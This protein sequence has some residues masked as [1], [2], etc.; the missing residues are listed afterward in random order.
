[1]GRGVNIVC[2]GKLGFITWNRTRP[3]A[4]DHHQMAIT[5]PTTQ[6]QLDHVVHHF[7]STTNSKDHRQKNIRIREKIV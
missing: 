7:R 5:V 1:M 6:L 3:S 2:V 4:S